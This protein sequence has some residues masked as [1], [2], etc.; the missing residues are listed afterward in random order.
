MNCRVT[1]GTRI[2]VGDGAIPLLLDL[3]GLAVTEDSKTAS[4][5]DPEYKTSRTV[6]IQSSDAVPG[7]TINLIL[8][9]QEQL[10]VQLYNQNMEFLES[11]EVYT[12]KIKGRVDGVSESKDSLTVRMPGNSGTPV[13]HWS[14]SQQPL[15]HLL[16]YVEESITTRNSRTTPPLSKATKRIHGERQCSRGSNR[17]AR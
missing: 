13:M 12:D 17:S 7:D 14:I 9:K 3:D 10:T 1:S 15:S 11:V 16:L 8:H 6:L 2:F 5:V 4:E